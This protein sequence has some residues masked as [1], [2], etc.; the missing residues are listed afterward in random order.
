M[1]LK[2]Y[3]KLKKKLI[4]FFYHIL[5]GVGNRESLPK[6]NGNPSIPVKLLTKVDCGFHSMKTTNI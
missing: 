6:T 2:N 1:S 3:S 4:R 5:I